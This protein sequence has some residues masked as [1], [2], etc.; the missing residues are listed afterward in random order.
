MLQVFPSLRSLPLRVLSLQTEELKGESTIDP[1][2]KQASLGLSIGDRQ[3][4]VINVLPI[5]TYRKFNPISDIMRCLAYHLNKSI[6]QMLK[7]Q[8]IKSDAVIH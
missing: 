3:T 7:D 2:E 8:Q 4:L 5:F 6:E 1:K